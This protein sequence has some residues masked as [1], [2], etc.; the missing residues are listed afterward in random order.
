VLELDV[1]KYN[2]IVTRAQL[3]GRYEFGDS[4]KGWSV[5]IAVSF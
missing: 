2:I 4:V 3:V 5:G 1:S